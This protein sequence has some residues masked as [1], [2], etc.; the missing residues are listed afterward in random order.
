MIAINRS[1]GEEYYKA[2]PDRAQGRKDSQTR[3][4]GSRII[5]GA[6]GDYMVPT[7]SFIEYK[8]SII[9]DILKYNV[10]YIAFE[11]PEMW[12]ASGYSEGFKRGVEKVLRYRL[13]GSESSPEAKVQKAPV[14]RYIF[15]KRQ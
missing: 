14:L 15:S 10:S 2:Y 5:H 3:K 8:W 7:D 11:E 9:E 4:D 1:F 13:G 6:D 12:Q